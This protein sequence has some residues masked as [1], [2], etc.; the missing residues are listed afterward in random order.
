MGEIVGSEIKQYRSDVA[1]NASSNG[2]GMSDNEILTGVKN[3]VFP[4]V[5]QA[6]LL[7]GVT[8]HRKVFHKIENADDETLFNSKIHLIENSDGDEYTSLIIGT[9][10]NT[11]GDLT[12]SEDE[13]GI[14]ELDDSVSAGESEVV[15]NAKSS[16][17]IMHRTGDTIFITDGVNSEYFE[18]VTV[19]KNSNQY[20]IAL[21]TG[22]SFGYDYNVSSSLVASVI[23]YGNISTDYSWDES[24]VVSAGEY[25]ETNYPITLN[26]IGTIEQIWIITFLSGDT[27]FSCVGNTVGALANGQIG[28]DYEPSHTKFLT[29][30][31]SIDA[32]GWGADFEEGDVIVL[33]THPCAAPI[34]R[35]RVVD[36][37]SASASSVG[38][39]VRT[40]G[41]TGGDLDSTTTT[42]S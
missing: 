18:N 10:T 23:E 7:S 1:N 13:Y 20:T 35:K 30:Y 24:G 15:V 27:T 5:T 26:N 9:L 16:T 41:E 34:W 25:D 31:F 19:V 21:D 29:P 40:T 11:E 8:H 42:T 33:T 38:Y 22:D 28:V 14:S 17:P 2:G 12:G 39:T 32:D 6:E 4:D 3:N 36:A 37:G